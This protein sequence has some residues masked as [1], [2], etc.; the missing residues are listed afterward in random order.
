VEKGEE[1]KELG[2]EEEGDVAA[3]VGDIQVIKVKRKKKKRVG[4]E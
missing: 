2:R 1:E 4:G 3:D